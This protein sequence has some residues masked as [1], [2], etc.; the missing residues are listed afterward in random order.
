M[1]TTSGFAY[2]QSH[3]ERLRILVQA[4]TLTE[5]DLDEIRHIQNTLSIGIEANTPHTRA[6]LEQRTSTYSVAGL[7]VTDS[8]LITEMHRGVRTCHQL[9]QAR[10]ATMAH[11]AR[12]SGGEKELTGWGSS[13]RAGARAGGWGSR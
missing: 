5:S 12:A 13:S 7:I 10:Q 11:D 4:E 3:L 9:L 8:A 6:G 2:P 1:T